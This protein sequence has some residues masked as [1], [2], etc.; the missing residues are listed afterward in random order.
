[1]LSGRSRAD[2]AVDLT[3]WIGNEPNR[4]RR[5]F[6]TTANAVKVLDRD[7]RFAG[8]AKHDERG[9]TACVHSF[10]VSFATHLNRGGVAPRVAQAAMRHSTID[11]TMSVYTDP[12]LLDVA[13]ALS[14]LPELPLNNRSA[15][16]CATATAS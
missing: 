7:L 16:E 14:V 12:K 6:R 3:R 9:R 8:I 13:A 4:M 2:L 5:L 1:M 11:L 10:R 15:F